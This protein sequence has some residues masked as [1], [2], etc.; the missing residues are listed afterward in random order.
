MD[1]SDQNK[2]N[3]EIRPKTNDILVHP[4]AKKRPSMDQ[5]GPGM[6]QNLDFQQFILKKV[7]ATPWRRGELQTRLLARQARLTAGKPA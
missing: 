6:G 2:K 7:P 4:C 5:D 3:T 1:Q